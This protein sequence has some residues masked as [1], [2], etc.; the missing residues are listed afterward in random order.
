[1]IYFSRMFYN[2]D[3]TLYI[4]SHLILATTLWNKLYVYMCVHIYAI[5]TYIYMCICIL[6]FK[7][8]KRLKTKNKK[9]S[10][11]G[12]TPVRVKVRSQTFIFWLQIRCLIW[13]SM[14]L[15][16]SFL[17]T[18]NGRIR[19]LL[20]M[21]VL[22]TGNWGT[23]GWSNKRSRKEARMVEGESLVGGLDPRKGRWPTISVVPK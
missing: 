12:H 6:S 2:Y 7:Q 8:I 22:C 17:G 23:L 15:L 3:V 18:A 10:F 5:Y 13:D 11:Y 20:E 19:S 9:P 21:W 14:S 4:P 16:T 1:M